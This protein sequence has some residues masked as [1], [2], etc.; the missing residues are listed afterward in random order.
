MSDDTTKSDAPKDAK[1][2]PP[3]NRPKA[4]SKPRTDDRFAKF[5]LKKGNVTQDKVKQVI[6]NTLFFGTDPTDALSRIRQ[7]H[8]ERPI[9]LSLTTRGIGFAL[10]SYFCLSSFIKNSR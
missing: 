4:A 9:Q 3:L 8:V 10:S 2:Q 7:S 6:K 1:S 5:R